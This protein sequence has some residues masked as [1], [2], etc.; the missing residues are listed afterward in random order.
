MKAEIISIGTELLLGQVVN[1]NAAYISR[2]LASLGIEV[3]HHVTVGDNKDRLIEAVKTAEERVDLIVMS[4]GL[5]PTQDDITKKTLS[6]YLDVELILHEETEEKIIS[7]HK[8]SDFKM[9]EN[10]QLQALILAD[11]TPL[12]ND[13]GLAI[14]MMLSRNNHHYVL[15]PGPPDELEPMVDNYLK[16]ELIKHILEEQVL[17]S[18]VLRFFGLT[19]AQL[20]EKI[21]GIISEQTNPTAA[22]YANSGEITVRITA[23]AKDDDEGYKAIDKV[24][25]KIMEKLSDY[26]FGYGEKT[27]VEVVKDRLKEKDLKIT[28]AESLTGGAF[29]SELTSVTEVSSILEGGMVTYSAD[30]KN[31]VLNVRKKTI[32]DFGVVSG[33][34]A[35]EMA[36]KAREMFDADIGVGLTGVAGPSSLEKQIPGT[37]WIGISYKGKESFSKHFH[38]S[39]KR[40]RNRRLAVLNALELVRRTIE[41]LPIDNREYYGE[42]NQ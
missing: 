16:N 19:E 4:G 5:G 17:V 12:S 13:T 24:E 15:L 21:D 32:E 33:E 6:D 31:K 20:A 28:A 42:D 3:Y 26:F 18:R 14:G 7:Y 11:S 10:N 2:E 27:L 40:N 25:T 30:K 23:K 34:C 9:P 8:N 41:D 36:E 39:Y 37:V 1:T 22:I 29:I 35:V 38:F